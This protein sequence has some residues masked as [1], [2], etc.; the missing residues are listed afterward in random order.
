MEHQRILPS[1][2]WH[3]LACIWISFLT[4]DL[5]TMWLIWA[6]GWLKIWLAVYHSRHAWT[7]CSTRWCSS[8]GSGYSRGPQFVLLSKRYG[9]SCRN[10]SQA[11]CP[12]AWESRFFQTTW[13]LTKLYSTWALIVLHIS[14]KFCDLRYVTLLWALPTPH[15][16]LAIGSDLELSHLVRIC[17]ENEYCHIKF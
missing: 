15:A 2:Q 7:T 1:L 16:T 14:K 6:T 9:A 5:E 4:M 10:H 13:G 3:N 12:T 8:Y 11:E 17:E